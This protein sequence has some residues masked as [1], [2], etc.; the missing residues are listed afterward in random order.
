MTP[1]H[2]AIR[3]LSRLRPRKRVRTHTKKQ[4]RK[5]A[6]SL[7]DFGWTAPIVVDEH[8]NILAGHARHEAALLNGW[9]QVPVL[10]LR[11]LT[12]TQ[13]RALSIADNRIALDA[14]WD[15]DLLSSELSELKDL[16]PE[17]NLGVFDLGFEPP[18]IDAIFGDRIDPEEDF[19]DTAPP[20]QDK[21]ISRSGDL[22]DL[23]G[24]HRIYC[25]S[26]LDSQSWKSLCGPDRAAAVISDPPY[27][28][29]IR[30]IVGRG[31]IRQREFL[32]ASGEMS[33]TQFREFLETALALATR[34]S[35]AGSLHYLFMDWR[36]AYDL[37]MV[38]RSV[39]TS[40][41]NLVVWVKTNGGM[42]SFYRSQHELIFVFK[43]GDAPHLNNIELGRHGRNR[44]NVWNHAGA[45]SFRAGRLDD[46][47]TH[48][49]VKPVG[50][51]A[52]AMR[53]CTKRGDIV[54]DPFLG[55]GSMI[56]AAEK[57]GRRGFG[58]ELDPLY[59]DAAIRRWQTSA[60]RDATLFGTG[61]TFEAV[62]DER[63]RKTE[64]RRR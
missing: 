5:L 22:W 35:V 60:R 51:I 61:Q 23:G 42:G 8:D 64:R 58:I 53:D 30:S 10:V 48:P 43:N 24:K 62:A 18:E 12:E 36:H 13:K 32:Q 16:L 37:Q 14:G 20:I 38:G 40:M 47:A 4:I 44:T 15:Q 63:A 21:A 7:R 34:Y 41:E 9:T 27:N 46:L 3:I 56:L 49:T 55:S 2:S 19:A 57:V 11:D 25:G 29:A 1:P 28:V 39:Y 31:A 6:K 45:N 54:I 52:D 26:S 17:L 59:S 33:E 50:L